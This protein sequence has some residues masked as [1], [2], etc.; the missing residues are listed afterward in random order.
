MLR[1]ADA[2]GGRAERQKGGKAESPHINGKAEKIILNKENPVA[3]N[4][5]SRSNALFHTMTRLNRVPQMKETALEKELS[6]KANQE[7]KQ[8]NQY[9]G[10]FLAR[11]GFLLLF[12]RQK[13]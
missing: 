6:E 5:L 7:A 3:L 2:Q 9:P 8:L 12:F 1:P 10:E 13:K 4:C 11:R